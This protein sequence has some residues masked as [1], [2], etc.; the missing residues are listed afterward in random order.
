MKR[1]TL[2]VSDQNQKAEEKLHE[3]HRESLTRITQDLVT[4]CIEQTQRLEDP[5]RV[6]VGERFNDL[7]LEGAVMS[8]VGEV[9]EADE[10]SD[11]FEAHAKQMLETWWQD[12]RGRRHALEALDA[13]LA[14]MPAAIAAPIALHTGG[15][16]AAE[17]VVFAGP[18][19]A[20]FVT[21]V[22]EYQFGDALFD[23]LSPWKSEQQA[24]CR[25]ALKRH[26]VDPAL[27][28]LRAARDATGG[29]VIREMGEALET[30]RKA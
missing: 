27:R 29:D 8:V 3:L 2:D 14:V 26:V 16:G 13:V 21:R 15:V 17:A 19:A 4:A 20:Q 30:C 1:A 28:P 23:F 25:E 9:F 24:L 18:I 11:A 10:V 5:A 7:D 22:M 6:L 12:H